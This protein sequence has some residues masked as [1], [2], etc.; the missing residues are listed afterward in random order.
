MALKIISFIFIISL[1]IGNPAPTQIKDVPF[2]ADKVFNRQATSILPTGEFLIDTSSSLRD[3]YSPAIAFDGS[4][5]LVV[6]QDA[7]ND[8]GDIYGARV[9]QDGN[10]LD[11][12]CIAISTANNSQ[13]YPSIAFDGNNYLVV[14]QDL[15][16]SNTSWDIYGARVSRAGVVLDQGGI[17]IFTD[18]LPELYPAV[19]FDGNNYLVVWGINNSLGIYGARVNQQGIVLDTA[20]IR[21]N[22][23]RDEGL[24]SD[25][26]F[27]DSNYLVVWEEIGSIPNYYNIYC[28]RVNPEGIVLNPTST[29]AVNHHFDP[30]VAFDGTNYMVVWFHDDGWMYGK[31]V[32]QQGIVLDPSGLAIC[33]ADPG[34]AYL[35][36]KIDFGSENYLMVWNDQ[37]RGIDFDIWEAGIL[38]SGAHSGPFAVSTQSGNQKAPDLI[39]GIGDEFLITYSGWTDSINHH[40]ANTMRIWGKFSSDIGIAEENSKVKIQSS[41]L[42]EVYPNPTRSVIRVRYPFTVEEQTDLK[43]FD[44]SGKIVKEIATS[45]TQTRNDGKREISLKGI[46]PGIYFLRLGK[47]TKK[48]L[49]VK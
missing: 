37:S 41:K 40:P 45:A 35:G 30:S 44:V 49:V 22:L 20:G 1:V 7:R 21:I 6:W 3:Q 5:Y 46:N 39:H 2:N 12:A 10:V 25:V 19:A 47:E 34:S 27:G 23:Q 9:D 48:F 31:R 26:A 33:T 24:F 11:P 42:L 17:A 18:A 32:N 38:P 28:V 16:N 13:A 29:I 36:P 15:R 43:I 8:P 14:W 4:N